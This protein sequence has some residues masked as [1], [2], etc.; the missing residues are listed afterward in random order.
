M[1]KDKVAK[2]ENIRCLAKE[3]QVPTQKEL[4]ELPA[5]DYNS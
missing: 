1:Y 3:T 2:I 4:K 5:Q